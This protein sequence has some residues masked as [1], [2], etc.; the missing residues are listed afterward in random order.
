MKKLDQIIVQRIS[1]AKKRRNASRISH[2]PFYIRIRKCVQSGQEH[3]ITPSSLLSPPLF[4]SRMHTHTHPPTPAHARTRRTLV[5]IEGGRI[6]GWVGHNPST[7]WFPRRYMPRGGEPTKVAFSPL[8]CMNKIL[9]SRVHARRTG[10]P[11]SF[12]GDALL[13]AIKADLTR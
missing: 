7:G 5:E 13:A 10:R 12:T 4:A 9:F 11:A 3:F 2:F 8:R 1:D 6:S